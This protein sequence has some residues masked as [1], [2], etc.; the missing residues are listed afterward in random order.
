[1][2]IAKEQTTG[3][4]APPKTQVDSGDVFTVGDNRDSSSDSRY[5]GFVPDANR[6]GSKIE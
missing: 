4:Y 2:G 1:M 6:L 5:W 3:P